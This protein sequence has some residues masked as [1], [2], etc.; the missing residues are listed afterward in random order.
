MF[1]KKNYPYISYPSLTHQ[2]R[3]YIFLPKIF[4]GNVF[5]REAVAYQA[6]KNSEL[7]KKIEALM[8]NFIKFS[9]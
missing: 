8:T 3:K 5:S 9:R 4:Y 7:E 6:Q 2:A 1:L